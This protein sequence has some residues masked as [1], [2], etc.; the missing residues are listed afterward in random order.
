MAVPHLS[1]FQLLAAN[2]AKIHNGWAHMLLDSESHDT[3]HFSTEDE[4]TEPNR[5]TPCCQDDL[6]QTSRKLY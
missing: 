6:S 2:T 5:S 4:L 1:H 3:R